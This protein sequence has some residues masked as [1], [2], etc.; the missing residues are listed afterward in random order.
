MKQ[1]MLKHASVPSPAIPE[2][3]LKAM[4]QGAMPPC[5]VECLVREGSQGVFVEVAVLVERV[6]HACRVHMRQVHTLDPEQVN[7]IREKIDAIKHRGRD[8][9]HDMQQKLRLR[10]KKQ[11]CNLD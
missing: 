3:I 5:R 2:L 6:V 11:K 4:A 10:T 7:N 8:K 9:I 1:H